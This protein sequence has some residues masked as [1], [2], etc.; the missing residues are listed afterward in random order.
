MV[1]AEMIAVADGDMRSD[2]DIAD[3]CAGADFGRRAQKDQREN[4]AA[5]V[6]LRG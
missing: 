1:M 6:P 2:T 3:M 5:S 4:R